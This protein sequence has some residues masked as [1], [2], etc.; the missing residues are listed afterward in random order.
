MK[1]EQHSNSGSPV[2]APYFYMDMGPSTGAGE[3]YQ[4][5]ELIDSSSSPRSYQFS[6]SFSVEVGTWRTIPSVA[7]SS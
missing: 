3:T 2:I 4:F 7:V 5:S 1:T 6:H